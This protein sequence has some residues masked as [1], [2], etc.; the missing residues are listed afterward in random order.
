MKHLAIKHVALIAG[1]LAASSASAANY[2]YT[3]HF[4]YIGKPALAA[5]QV[6]AQTQIDSAACDAAVVDQY[7]V[8]SASYRA[9]MLQRGWKYRLSTRTKVS[10]DPAD[11]F[12]SANVKLKPGHFIDHDSGL[13]CRNM[14]G[15]SVCTAPTGT[16]HYYDPDKHL[17]C[18]RTGALSI[19]TNL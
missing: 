1:L 13:D 4:D 17:P 6:D 5:S 7:A 16:V 19:C 8:P 15:A 11:P 10:T 3:A 14:G 12:Y 2:H 18:T 9:C